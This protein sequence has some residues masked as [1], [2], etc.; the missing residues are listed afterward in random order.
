VRVAEAP[1]RVSLAEAF[2][3]L[4]AVEHG[5]PAAAALVR[6]VTP[7]ASPDVV[8]DIVR[9]VLDRLQEQDVRQT[10]VEVAERLVREE[11][12]RIKQAGG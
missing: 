6:P 2:S 7:A 8:E 11:I 1:S 4:L 10:V 9:R 12:D 5:Q 3:T